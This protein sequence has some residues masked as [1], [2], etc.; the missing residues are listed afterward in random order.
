[1]LDFS[2]QQLLCQRDRHD[3][4]G[5]KPRNVVR[6]PQ[7]SAI[8]HRKQ[9]CWKS[10]FASERILNRTHHLFSQQSCSGLPGRTWSR[11]SSATHGWFAPHWR[12]LGFLGAAVQVRELLQLGLSD[13][14][15]VIL[16]TAKTCVHTS[17]HAHG[18]RHAFNYTG[19]NS[20]LC[21]RGYSPGNI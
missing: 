17:A 10:L 11:C 2:A 16:H 4:L 9:E 21:L 7:Q 13:L 19:L 3:S 14:I 6:Q 18:G 5:S 20:S 8:L 15:I 12:H 1:M